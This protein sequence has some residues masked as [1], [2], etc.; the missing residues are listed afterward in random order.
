M[1]KSSCHAVEEIVREWDDS[2]LGELIVNHF[3]FFLFL[4]ELLLQLLNLFVC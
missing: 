3:D 2:S 4:L 1:R